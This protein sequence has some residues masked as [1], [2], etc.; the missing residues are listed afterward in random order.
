MSNSESEN[1]ARDRK[2]AVNEARREAERLGVAHAV[3]LF[4]PAVDATEFR[5]PVRPVYANTS[6]ATYGGDLEENRRILTE[7]LINPVSFAP[8]V[9]AMY[10]DGFRIFVEFGPKRVLARLV[11]A[12]LPNHSGFIVCA[13][14]GGP[15]RDSDVYLKRTAVELAAPP[16]RRWLT[17]SAVRSL[18]SSQVSG[19]CWSGNTLRVSNE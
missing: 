13:I 4:R 9:R 2:I 10:Q 1:K 11:T 5:P 15:G 16:G 19:G 14:D 3:E 18:R 12:S 7:Q 17:P 8:Q 6:G